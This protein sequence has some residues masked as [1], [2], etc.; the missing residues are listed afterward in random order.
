MPMLINLHS[1]ELAKEY[2]RRIIGIREGRVV[3]D[4]PPKDLDDSVMKI[5]YQGVLM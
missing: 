5:I 2:A 1:V 4:G 3:F